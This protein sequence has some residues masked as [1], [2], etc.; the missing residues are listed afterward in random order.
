M[1]KTLSLVVPCYY[2]EQ[3][4]DLFYAAVED[5]KSQLPGLE[6]EYWFINDGSRDQTLAKMRALQAR[7]PGHVHYASFSRNFGKEAA[8]LCGLRLATGDY[9]TVMDADLQ[10]PPDMLPQMVEILE[11]T[12]Y[13]CVGTRRVDREGEPPIRS[14][15]ARMFYRIIN[16]ISDSEIVDGA[17][18]FRVMTRP[19]VNSVLELSEY[20]RFSKGIF[21]WVGYKTKYL[22]YENRERVAGDTS[23]NFWGLFKYSIDGLVNFS[24]FPLD[25]AS[26]VGLF[27]SLFSGLGILFIVIRYLMYGDRTT[28]WASMV[29][30]V[31]F[32]GGIQLLCLGILGKYIGKIF[33]EVKHRPIYI[34][35]EKK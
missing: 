23:W 26:L 4:I 27:S 6:L 16:K 8:M 18:D 30:I 21:S 15:F 5:I 34:V 2:E 33:T 22:P 32:I 17:R 7:D 3:T 13:D 14:F 12:D 10:D 31:L 24:Q 9:V 20:N 29:C 25:I 11:T 19:F 1:T 35:K 28:G